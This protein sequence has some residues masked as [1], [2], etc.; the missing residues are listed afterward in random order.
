MQVARD[1]PDIQ[2]TDCLD[3]MNAIVNTCILGSNDYGGV[4]E[5][6]RQTYNISDDPG[7]PPLPSST[8]GAPGL[9]PTACKSGDDVATST[10]EC[11]V[12]LQFCE[13]GQRCVGVS[14]GAGDVCAI[15]DPEEPVGECPFECFGT[16]PACACR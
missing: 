15:F 10:D 4:A 13:N 1:S 5:F 6:N 2:L 16:P 9:E 12:G 8:S 14:H 11:C 3:C 7:A